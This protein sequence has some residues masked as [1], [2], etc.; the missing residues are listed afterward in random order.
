MK[1]FKTVTLVSREKAL[2]IF[3]EMYADLRGFEELSK[4]EYLPNKVFGKTHK[5]KS[6]NDFYIQ[7]IDNKDEEIIWCVPVYFIKEGEE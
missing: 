6:V 1:N 5:V 4:L 7:I 3:D 2:E